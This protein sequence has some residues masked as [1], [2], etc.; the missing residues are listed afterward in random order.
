MQK[1]SE[2]DEVEMRGKNSQPRPASLSTHSKTFNQQTGRLVAIKKIRVA[3]AS[4]GVSVTAL[5]EVK[6]LRELRGHPNVLELLDAFSHKSRSGGGICL[7]FEFMDS[8]TWRPW[9]TTGGSCWAPETSSAT[10]RPC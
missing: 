4:E 8:A 10:S 3:N 2:C 7:V 5:R 1:L 6:L 9:R